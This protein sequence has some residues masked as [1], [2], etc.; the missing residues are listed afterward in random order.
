[1]KNPVR[2]RRRSGGLV[3]EDL[4]HEAAQGWPAYQASKSALNAITIT[5]AKFVHDDG[6]TVTAVC[7][8][9]V[10]THIHPAE[11]RGRAC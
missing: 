10:Q 8:G 9:F 1:M 2:K 3:F 7:S 6:N 5:P 4:L 11:N